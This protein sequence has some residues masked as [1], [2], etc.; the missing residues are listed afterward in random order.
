M[1]YAVLELEKTIRDKRKELARNYLLKKNIN[2]N[3]V[4][5]ND[6]LEIY[7]LLKIKAELAQSRLLNDIEKDIKKEE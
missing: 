7:T 1:N 5:E 4:C 3:Q 6:L 2:A